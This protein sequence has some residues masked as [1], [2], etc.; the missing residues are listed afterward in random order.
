MTSFKGKAG[1]AKMTSP[2]RTGMPPNQKVNKAYLTSLSPQTLHNYNWQTI[3][4]ASKMGDCNKACI[5]TKYQ[6]TGL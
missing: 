2:K 5:V 1:W 6:F 4:L 3:D